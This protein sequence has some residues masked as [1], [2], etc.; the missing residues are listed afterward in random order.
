MLQN[1]YFL[2]PLI[3][4]SYGSDILLNH[5]PVVKLIVTTSN[6]YLAG[7]NDTIYSTFKGE[8]AESGPHPIGSF[9]QGETIILHIQLTRVIGS[10]RSIELQIQGTDGWLMSNLICYCDGYIYE[11]IVSLEWLDSYDPKLAL[12]NGGDGYEPLAHRWYRNLSF[13]PTRQLVVVKSIR[14]MQ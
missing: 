14:I 12:T 1:F 10:L 6:A 7:T 2:I 5:V 3:Y 11:M 13:S 9:T 4:I 8:F